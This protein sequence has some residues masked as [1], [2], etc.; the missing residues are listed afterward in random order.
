MSGSPA[1]EF[2]GFPTKLGV[3]RQD[4]G[5][6]SG[7]PVDAEF[8]SRSK[9]CV[10]GRFEEFAPVRGGEFQHAASSGAL[11]PVRSDCNPYPASPGYRLFD[12]KVWDGRAHFRFGKK[13]AQR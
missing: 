1:G 5:E 3:G 10:A 11:P 6:A 13:L 8:E 2:R 4:D 7:P 9:P 12:L